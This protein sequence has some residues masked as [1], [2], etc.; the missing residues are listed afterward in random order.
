MRIREDVRT[1][2]RMARLVLGRGGLDDPSP[3]TGDYRRLQNGKVLTLTQMDVRADA[4]EHLRSVVLVGGA[5]RMP[6]IREVVEEE[7]GDLVQD[8]ELLGIDPVSAVALGLARGQ[9]LSIANL[10]YP[11][12]GI[13][14]LVSTANGPVEIPLYEP[15][16]PTFR[17]SDGYTATYRYTA[18]LPTG[19]ASVGLSFRPVGEA[20][21]EAWAPVPVPGDA[22]VLTLDLDLFGRVALSVGDS[23]LLSSDGRATPWMPPEGRTMPPWIA[24]LERSANPTNCSH[25]NAWGHCPFLPCPGHPLGGIDFSED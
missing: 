19:A 9:Q 6:M 12:W 10:R 21:G 17:L 20:R 11:S 8:P 3:G 25:G 1:A 22:R 13:S 4:A 15:Y 16:A 14:A 18:S 23:I 5:S 2:Y 7:F 24:D